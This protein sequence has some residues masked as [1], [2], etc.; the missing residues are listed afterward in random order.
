MPSKFLLVLDTLHYPSWSCLYPFPMSLLWDNEP[1]GLYQLP[2]HAGICFDL[3]NEKR[4]RRLGQKRRPEDLFH[5]LFLTLRG[6]SRAGYVLQ[7]SP[8]LLRQPS[9]PDPLLHFFPSSQKA[10]TANSGH[11]ILPIMYVHQA[12]TKPFSSYFHLCYSFLL[13]PSLIHLLL[14]VLPSSWGCPLLFCC[15]VAK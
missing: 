4:E 11:C 10:V 6:P 2:L 8:S 3:A 5:H 15:S 7:L 13:G 14:K 9:L 12:H 1:Y